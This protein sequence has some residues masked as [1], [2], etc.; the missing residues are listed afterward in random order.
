MI[1][2]KAEELRGKAPGIIL[3]TVRKSFKL[4]PYYSRTDGSGVSLE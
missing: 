2:I 4:R 3:N 1:T